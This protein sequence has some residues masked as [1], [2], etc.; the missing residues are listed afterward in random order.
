MKHEIKIKSCP[1]LCIC[2]DSGQRVLI[3]QQGLIFLFYIYHIQHVHFPF[4]Y[5]HF[6]W[7]KMAKVVSFG[8]RMSFLSKQT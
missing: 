2:A 4:S 3:S 7:N 5:P 1:T 6:P 8:I